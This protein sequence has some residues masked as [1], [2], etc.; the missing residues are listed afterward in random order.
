M[1]SQRKVDKAVAE[2]GKARE[3]EGLAMGRLRKVMEVSN[4]NGRLG[5][6]RVAGARDDA[7]GGGGGGESEGGETEDSERLKPQGRRV[8]SRC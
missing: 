1:N 6:T 4:S 7:G 5:A 2:E 3:R 8:T